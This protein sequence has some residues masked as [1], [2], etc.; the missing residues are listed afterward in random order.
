MWKS[1]IQTKV[2]CFKWIVMLDKL[3]V[4]RYHTDSEICSLCRLPKTGRHI[5]FDCTFA[6][7]IWN[8][9]GFIYPINVNILDIVSGHITGVHKDTNLF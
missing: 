2:R 7:E 9:F 6:K 5:L 4:K 1:P 8:M 3:L